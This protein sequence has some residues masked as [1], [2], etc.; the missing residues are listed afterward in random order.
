MVRWWNG[1]VV[2]VCVGMLNHVYAAKPNA[3]LYVCVCLEVCA[4]VCT[5][6]CVRVSL[7]AAIKVAQSDGGK[8]VHFLKYHT[9]VE[10]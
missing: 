1:L 3:G 9:Q 5:R 6:V 10:F 4:C 8:K 2:Y 7:H